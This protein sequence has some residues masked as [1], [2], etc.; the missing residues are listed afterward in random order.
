MIANHRLK[1]V[2][3]PMS[4]SRF[5]LSL[6]CGLVAFGCRRQQAE[7]PVHPVVISGQSQEAG[8]V[9]EAN[10]LAIAQRAVA[11]NDAKYPDWLATNV[12]YRA[13]R[14]GRG[15]SVL[16]EIVITN[17]SGEPRVPVGAQRYIGIDER[18]AVTHY[19]RGL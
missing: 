2:V 18:G 6:A 14:E 11:T 19:W 3:K 8:T 7:Q 13:S 9:T 4:L 10:A 1:I 12:F 15:W 5:V 16:A 17:D